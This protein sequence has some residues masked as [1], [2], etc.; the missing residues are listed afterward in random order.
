MTRPS[1][2]VKVPFER[3]AAPLAAR[4]LA[5][6]VLEVTPQERPAPGPGEVLI[7][8]ERAGVCGT[9]VHIVEGDYPL[10]RF[11]LVPGH[12]LAGTVVEVGEAVRRAHVGERVTVDPNVPCLAC[13]ECRR[14][15]FN[16]CEDMS[17]VGVNRD[18]GFASYLVVPERA[19][20]PV[21]DLSPAAAAL[22]EPLACVLWGLKRARVEP[23]ARALVFGAGPMGCLLLQ[24][25]RF[26]GAATVA[27]VDKVPYRLEV[28]RELGATETVPADDRAAVARLAQGGFDLVVDATGVP[29]VLQGA[30]AYARAGGTVWSFGVAPAEARIEVSPFELFRR[31]LTL[32]GSFALNRTFDRAI[33]LA[34]SPGMEL[35]ALV[36]H[37]VP[38][39]EFAR[40][41]DVARREP[42]RLK[43]QF[44]MPA[45][46]F[47]MPASSAAGAER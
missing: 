17:I 7:A 36:S 25:L 10:T 27:V 20:Y 22:V 45:L 16:H 43:V 28:A 40:G 8:V 19:V 15:A 6:E 13:P 29:A 41:L 44:A 30:L 42:R 32:F 14:N 35:D 5:P 18:G 24:A 23:G 46:E 2:S 47:A 33:E 21:G 4:V 1:T 9:D 39:A 11:P 34:R 38:L 31:D 12:E 37:V 26:A 3:A